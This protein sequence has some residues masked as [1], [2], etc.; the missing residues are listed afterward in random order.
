MSVSSAERAPAP[1]E[2]SALS[3]LNRRQWL[4]VEAALEEL[5]RRSVGRRD[6][7]GT[8]G[9]EVTIRDGTIQHFERIER[10]KFK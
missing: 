6:F 2:L 1:V 4:A 8:I 9:L 7:F 5:R 10:R 3:D